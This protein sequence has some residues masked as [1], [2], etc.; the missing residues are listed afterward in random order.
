MTENI[1]PYSKARTLIRDG[2]ALLWR[3]CSLLGRFLCWLSRG[4]FLGPSAK[5]SHIGMAHWDGNVLLD[6]QMLQWHG[7]WPR[8]LSCEI[9]QWP[10]LCDVLRVPDLD[11]YKATQAAMH[12]AGSPYGWRDFA[13]IWIARRLPFGRTALRPRNGEKPPFVCSGAF[14]AWAREGGV[15]RFPKWSAHTIIPEDWFVP[16]WYQFTIG[17]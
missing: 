6:V 11:G 12:M 8:N 14:T 1:L 13:K 2:D 3:S 7:G 10:G 16:E 9:A 15:D 17:E 4:T 5:H